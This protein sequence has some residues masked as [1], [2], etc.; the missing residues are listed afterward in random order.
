VAQMERRCTT[1]KSLLEQLEE[2][3]A[4]IAASRDLLTRDPG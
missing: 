4:Q 3:E 2:L 1:A